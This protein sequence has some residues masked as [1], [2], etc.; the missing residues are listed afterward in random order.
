MPV[1]QYDWGSRPHSEHGV[2]LVL[3]QLRLC[4]IT[5][6]YNSS[7]RSVHCDNCRNFSPKN[8]TVVAIFEYLKIDPVDYKFIQDG[9]YMAI[10]RQLSQF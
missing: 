3:H 7:D 9:V 1:V 2:L 6:L 5:G 8:A 4:Q 10:S